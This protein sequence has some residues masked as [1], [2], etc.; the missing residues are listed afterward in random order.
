MKPLTA[1]EPQR[2]VGKESIYIDDKPATSCVAN[3][4]QLGE[5]KKRGFNAVSDSVMAK[6]T[7]Q[8]IALL[9]RQ[10]KYLQGVPEFRV[11]KSP[12]SWFQYNP[13]R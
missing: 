7:R 3:L 13:D 4:F 5:G 6:P 2:E 10:A 12:G 11:N 9:A 8:S 1:H